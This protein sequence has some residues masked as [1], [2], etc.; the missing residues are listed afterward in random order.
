MLLEE[1]EKNTE[2]QRLVFCDVNDIDFDMEEDGPTVVF[3]PIVDGKILNRNVANIRAT[4][5]S[6]NRY[7]PYVKIRKELGGFGLV[8]KL[9]TALT[10]NGINIL[11]TKDR[12]SNMEKNEDI[13]QELENTDNKNESN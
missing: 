3:T 9:I 11:I 8:S 7:V 5:K 1:V 10:L 12:L 2:I 6:G 13:I 4:K